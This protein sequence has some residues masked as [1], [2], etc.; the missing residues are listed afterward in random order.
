MNQYV[1]RPSDPYAPPPYR[2]EGVT[3]SAFGV[4]A[5]RDVLQRLVEAELNAT[6][7]RFHVLLPYV[8]VTYVAIDRSWSVSAPPERRGYFQE[9]DLMVW[10]IVGR[11]GGVDHFVEIGWYVPLVWVSHPLAVIEGREAMGYPKAPAVIAN[12]GPAGPF[13]TSSYVFPGN[14]DAEVQLAMIN[15]VINQQNKAAEVELALPS[16]HAA[17]DHLVATTSESDAS[18]HRERHRDALAGFLPT[19]ILL[20]R[21]LAAGTD[22]RS[23]ALQQVLRSP[24]EDLDFHGAGLLRGPWT[25]EFPGE[26]G[27]RIA[28]YLGVEQTNRA[29]SLIA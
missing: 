19:Q 7:C 10:L 1:L 28:E 27:A 29:A 23:A 26:A 14:V 22:T 3:I 24:V 20:L 15:Q 6:G 16:L 11:V 5:D 2:A 8:L 13:Q 12:P 21:E 17:W 18:P 4:R 25:V 9:D